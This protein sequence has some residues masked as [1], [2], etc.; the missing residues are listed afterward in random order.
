[1]TDGSIKGLKASFG[2]G[3]ARLRESFTGVVG[4]GCG[5]Y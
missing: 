4:L 2:V 5:V 3:F 1:M